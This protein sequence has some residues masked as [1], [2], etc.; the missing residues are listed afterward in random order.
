MLDQGRAFPMRLYV[1]FAVAAMASALPFENYA[2]AVDC[3]ERGK[4]AHQI[5]EINKQVLALNAQ[6]RGADTVEMCHLTKQ[7]EA[8]FLQSISIEEGSLTHCGLSDAKRQ[9]L[10]D[11]RAGFD[12]ARTSCSTNWK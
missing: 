1:A 10:L 11:A 7:G 4:L 5:A 9:K 3:G 12:A 6:Y 8:L 2:F